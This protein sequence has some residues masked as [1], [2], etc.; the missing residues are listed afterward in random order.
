MLQI[1]FQIEKNQNIQSSGFYF[2]S[3]TCV[4]EKFD[5]LTENIM[6]ENKIIKEEKISI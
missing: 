1:Q 4:T 3:I 5:A 6:K 2:Q